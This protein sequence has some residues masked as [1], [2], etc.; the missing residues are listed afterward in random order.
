MSGSDVP[1]RAQRDLARLTAKDFDF[2]P[3]PPAAAVAHQEAES[4]EE[5]DASVAGA[6][7]APATGAQVVCVADVKAERVEWLWRGR[8]PL[9]KITVLD[10]DPG[11]GK[12][13]V[14]LDLVARI[15]RGRPMPGEAEVRGPA[16]TLLLSAEDGLA[17]TIRPR[18]EAAGADLT[19]VHA[20]M[21]VPAGSGR[22]PPEIPLDLEMI[23]EEAARR[24]VALIIIDPLFAY[25]GSSVNARTD[26]DVRR[27][28]APLAAVAE[29]TNAAVLVVRHLNKAPGGPAVYRGGGSIGI[30]GAA[31]SGLLLAADP[32]DP[33]RRV[34][35]PIKSNLGPAPPAMALHLEAQTADAVAR[36]VWD[37]TTR[38]RAADLLRQESPEVA[39]AVE[40]AREWLAN[41]LADGDEHESAVLKEVAR[42]A[43]VSE[44]ALKRAMKRLGVEHEARGFPRQT[45]WRLPASTSGIDPRD[46]IGDVDP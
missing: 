35:A 3:R 26:H 10:G 5:P 1:P 39:D 17:D 16:N 9:G 43:G 24:E 8:I 38:H 27:A 45:Y 6:V 11:L 40:Q 37:G 20:L 42:A 7:D 31:R 34:L 4:P 19:L 44:S 41:A 36:V 25:L 32:D 14:T 30:I 28:L 18:L 33:T 13:T 23:E 2:R 15:S 21:D 12:S 22:R 29:R 46:P